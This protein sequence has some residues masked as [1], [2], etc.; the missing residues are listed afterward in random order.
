MSLISFGSAVTQPLTAPGSPL[1]GAVKGT[2]T[3]PLTPAGPRWMCARMGAPR[4]RTV[5]AKQIRFGW[6][7]ASTVAE[8]RPFGSPP[9]GAVALLI[10]LLPLRTANSGFLRFGNA[11]FDDGAAPAPL[12]AR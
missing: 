12:T 1:V 9:C 5:I 4:P 7:A 10:S 3:G 11:A 2:T 6:R 8:P